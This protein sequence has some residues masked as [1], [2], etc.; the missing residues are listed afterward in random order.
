MTS[1]HV[2]LE[3]KTKTRISHQYRTNLTNPMHS[4]WR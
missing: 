2:S 3:A 4:I 1:M